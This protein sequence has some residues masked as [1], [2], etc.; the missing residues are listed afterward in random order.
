MEEKKK[1]VPEGEASLPVQEL[2]TDIPAEVRQ[3]LA[4][5]LNEE[6]TED[7]K[8]DIREAEKEEALA[9]LK[10][11]TELLSN[12]DGTSLP[13]AMSAYWKDLSRYNQIVQAKQ[14]AVPMLFLQG[15]RDFQVHQRH[16]ELWK[17]ALSGRPD[18]QFIL[19]DELNHLLQP[20][21]G[22]PGLAEYA[23]PSRVPEK[24]ADDIAAFIRQH[25]VAH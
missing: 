17:T 11:Q 7:L 22:T 15:K 13:D 1:A 20:G 23:T 5:D 6:A 25:T 3:K 10:K 12:P 4:E 16:L 24:V 2:P 14:I 9:A 8:Q 18:C 19:Y 21:T